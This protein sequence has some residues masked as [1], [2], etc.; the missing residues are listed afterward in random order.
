MR[1]ARLDNDLLRDMDKENDHFIWQR[2]AIV[3]ELQELKNNAAIRER[4]ISRLTNENVR[5]AT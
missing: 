5:L 4:E 3:D 2:G 1:D